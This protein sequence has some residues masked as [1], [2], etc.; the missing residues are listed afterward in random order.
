MTEYD[1]KEKRDWRQRV[2]NE[3]DRRAY[4]PRRERTTLYLPGPND[5]DRRTALNKGWSPRN[6]IAVDVEKDHV[7]Q[8][9]DDDLLQ[10]PGLAINDELADV[11]VNWPGDWPIHVIFADYCAG[12][13]NTVG[14]LYHQSALSPAIGPGTVFAVNLMRGRDADSNW[15]REQY[16]P[17]KELADLFN[18]PPDYPKH[19]GWQFYWY[20]FWTSEMKNR[21]D[22]WNALWSRRPETVVSFLRLFQDMTQPWFNSYR[23]KSGRITMDTVVFV[24]PWQR[25]DNKVLTTDGEVQSVPFDKARKNFESRATQHKIS[26]CRAVRTRR[27]GK[28]S[29]HV[30]HMELDNLIESSRKSI[31]SGEG[32]V[33]TQLFLE[34][35]RGMNGDD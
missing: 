35:L 6:L 1:Y 26:A 11:V 27:F 2:W 23:A 12:F 5:Y 13:I 28:D 7:R 17:P 3:I 32:R 31:S 14:D 4:A 16:T 21:Y 15:F 30:P 25:A 19:R 18:A 29:E 8:V 9:R 10:G 22:D 20:A 34:R 24:W 33:I